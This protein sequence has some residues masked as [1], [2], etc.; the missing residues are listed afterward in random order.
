LQSEDLK[1][2]YDDEG[3]GPLVVALPS[4]GDGRAEFRFIRPILVKAGYRFVAVDPRGLG[5]SSTEG[6]DFSVAGIGRDLIALLEG[7]DA[8]PAILIGESM[9]AGA[10]VFAAAE[11]PDLVSALVLMGPFVR[12]EPS[13]AKKLLYGL[14][15][16]G[17]WGA[18][19][20]K[21]YY[22]SLYPGKKV[23][24]FEDYLAAL[25]RN[26]REPGRLRALRLMLYASKGESERRLPRV[27]A[28]SLVIMG[29]K[30]PD[31]RNPAAEAAWV[32]QALSGTWKMM[33]GA[34]HYPQAEY[35]EETAALILE[36]LAT[37]AIEGASHA[38]SGT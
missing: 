15:F 6:S 20:W 19:A 38:A 17:P 21:S 27:K 28:P 18:A 25:G 11:R 36:F 8:G 35:P 34:G 1:L 3:T 31:F 16:S 9:S 29:E 5:E 13:L 26:L 24:D 23:A 32:A 7:L 30:D 2:A 22:R 12:S 10:S 14:L 4:M 37:T 33:P